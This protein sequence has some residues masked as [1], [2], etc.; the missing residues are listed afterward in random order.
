VGLSSPLLE[1]E[2]R[3]FKVR[4]PANLLSGALGNLLDNALYWTRF[5]KERD[6]R[7]APGAVLIT[8]D[9]D[10]SANTGLIA[11]VDNG[12][13]FQSR[14]LARSKRSTPRGQGA[15]DLDCIS[16]ISSWSSAGAN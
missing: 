5:R 13:V 9:W 16:P 15:W 6:E 12:Q 2:E 10:K 4:G 11:V 1:K 7:S 8:S 14:Q 3:D